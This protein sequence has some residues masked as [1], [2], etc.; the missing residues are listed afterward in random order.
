VVKPAEAKSE[1]EAARTQDQ[2]TGGDQAAFDRKMEGLKQRM[3]AAQAKGDMA[4]VMRLAD[5]LQQ[6]VGAPSAATAAATSTRMQE[7]GRTCGAEPVKPEPPAPT[8]YNQPNLDA[9][10]AGAAGLTPEQYAILR[11][12]V[13]YAVG[14]DGTVEVSSSSQWAFSQGELAVLQKRGK[15]LSHAFRPIRDRSH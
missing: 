14:E 8:S 11:E 3:Q 9:A 13:Q 6:A 15:E 10:G 12:R 5:S 4:E 2:I 7:A 1:A